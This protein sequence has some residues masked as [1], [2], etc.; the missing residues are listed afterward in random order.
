MLHP[1]CRVPD[2]VDRFSRL[3]SRIGTGINLSIDLLACS[4]YW[5]IHGVACWI[6]VDRLQCVVQWPFNVKLSVGESRLML[7]WVTLGIWVE[8]I[9]VDVHGR[10]V[11]ES[12]ACS[13]CTCFC[14]L[15]RKRRNAM[16]DRKS[17][18]CVCG[19]EWRT[20]FASPFDSVTLLRDTGHC[21]LLPTWNCYDYCVSTNSN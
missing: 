1:V 10:G 9:V 15:R 13:G 21:P 18:F 4:L 7:L 12:V 6:Q 20:T 5:L 19:F 8:L 14:L 11:V 3:P 16:N 17:L 2:A